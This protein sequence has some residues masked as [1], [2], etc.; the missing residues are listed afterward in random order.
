MSETI[1]NKAPLII[2]VITIISEQNLH[3]SLKVLIQLRVED[4]F[5]GTGC[6]FYLNC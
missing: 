2:E 1:M 6:P 5:I 4:R 3:N